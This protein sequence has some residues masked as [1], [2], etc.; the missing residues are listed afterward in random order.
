MSFDPFAEA[1]RPMVGKGHVWPPAGFVNLWKR[2]PKWWKPAKLFER[3]VMDASRWEN[4]ISVNE[5]VNGDV[6]YRIDKVMYGKEDRWALPKKYGDCEDYALAK[7]KT[8]ID[9]GWPAGCFAIAVCRH[10]RGR[11]HAVLLVEVNAAP[12]GTIAKP[13]TLVLDNLTDVVCP[14]HYHRY[15]WLAREVPGRF[16]WER[17]VPFHLLEKEQET[18]AV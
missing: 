6:T 14:W 17:I 16:L 15:G 13:L 3:A 10:W 11:Y 2:N 18:V 8:L 4:L 7:R 5:L 9:D 12:I 1:A